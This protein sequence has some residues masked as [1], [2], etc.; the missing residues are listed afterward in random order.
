MAN[1]FQVNLQLQTGADFYQEFYL[2]NDDMSPI[3]LTGISLF[4][5]LQKHSRSVD[6]NSV[7]SDRVYTRFKTEIVDAPGGTYA[8][9]LGRGES[10]KLREGKYVYDITMID[11]Q[12]QFTPVASGLMFVDVGFGIIYEDNIIDGGYPGQDIDLD[13]LVID[14]G[15]PTTLGSGPN[16][17]GGYPLG[18]I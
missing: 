6:A 10:N 5:T 18:Y 8:I 11:P 13:E 15:T 2:R 7:N 16:I 3:D 17:D 1:Q 4:A 12:G 14:G 9:T